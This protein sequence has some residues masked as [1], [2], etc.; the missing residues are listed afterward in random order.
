[1]SVDAIDKHPK[2][3]PKE[4]L[5]SGGQPPHDEGMEARVARLEAI[6]EHVKTDIGDL[7]ADMRGLRTEVHDFRKE[8]H[9]DTRWMLAALGAGFLILL[10]AMAH[11]FHW[12]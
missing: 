7:R 1:M 9:A 10:G 8:T 11:G 3:A 6:A 4:R 12:F 5:A 2:Y